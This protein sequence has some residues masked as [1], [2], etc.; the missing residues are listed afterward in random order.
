MHAKGLRTEASAWEQRDWLSVSGGADGVYRGGG[1]VCAAEERSP[2][3]V[4]P[5]RNAHA[6][7]TWFSCSVF[8]VESY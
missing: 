7:P 4:S 2:T 6:T 1:G 8:V 3:N 5:M